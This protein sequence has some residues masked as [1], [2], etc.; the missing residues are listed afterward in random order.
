MMRVALC[1]TQEHDLRLVVLA[2]LICLIGSAATV[3]LF[4]RVKASAGYSRLGWIVLTAVGTGTMVWATHFVAM[5]AY[6]ATAPVVLDP[7]LTLLSLLAVI[8]LAVP[9]LAIA[10]RRRRWGG[11]AGGAIIGVG[12]SVMHYV[13]MSAYRVDGIVTWEWRY[14]IA[15]VLL[16]SGIAALAFHILNGRGNARSV[17]AI[18][19]FATGVTVLHFTG[20]AAM[21][22]AVLRLGEG[23]SD[24]TMV[25]LA[26]TTT[27]ATCIIVGCA[28]ISALI[29]G[30]SQTEAY[31]R[32]R[33]MAMHD[34]LTDLPNR[35]SFIEELERRFMVEGGYPCMAV[36]MMD[37]SRFKV[38]NDTYGHQAGDQLLV[39]L[40]AR[41]TGMLQPGECIARLGGDEFACVVSYNT[42]DELSGFLTRLQKALTDTFVFDR[43]SAAISGNIGVAL[44]VHDGF[45]ADALLAK[46]DLAM[47][48][49]KSAHSGEPCFYDSQMDDAVRERRELIADLRAAIDTSAFELHFQ[50]QASIPSGEIAGYE[51]LVRW[52][53]PVRGM[54][55]PSVFIPL[56][57]KSGDIVPLSIW[58]LRQA[59]FEAALWPNRYPVAV[60]LSPIHL[61][62]PRLVE[63]VQSA[64]ADS[65]LPPERLSL[66][67][68]E[69]AIIHDRRFALEQLAALKAMGISIALD[70]FGVGYSSLDVLRSFPFDRIKLDASF[71][72]EIETDEQAVSI[73]RSV[74]A[75]GTTLNMPV[76][77]EGVEQ[78]AQLSIV[79]REG[80]SAI[81]GYLIGKPSR[82]LAE[83]EE[84]R[85]TISLKPQIVQTG[86]AVA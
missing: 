45:D 50:V 10:A 66:E 27:V 78:P 12:V 80:C 47:Y 14:V 65:G 30:Q 4:N 79:T 2:L 43:F 8:C 36:I 64:L 52:R 15:S 26:V 77:A 22:V 46:A 67:L 38:V 82:T 73:L 31:T 69:S 17:K 75:L 7:I 60:N 28:A 62:D 9:G 19:L 63:T 41:M 84:V 76:L 20:M 57:E 44:A 86:S 55:P 21:S 54:V 3:Q 35:T 61:A 51:A 32:L 18:G 53:H 42:A 68:T 11:A 39:A 25:A 33:R 13:G 34:G 48:R 83:P 81:Q 6:R 56:A 23:L 49:A 71:V 37:L 72:A 40:S 1:I 74:A 29:D 16:S 5:M 59:C 85:R 58:I 70:D 24:L